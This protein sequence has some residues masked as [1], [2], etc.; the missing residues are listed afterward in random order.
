MQVPAPTP[1]I[2]SFHKV[3]NACEPTALRLCGR[4]GYQIGWGRFNINRLI[5][6]SF[7]LH[8]G[9]EAL[10]H[11]A[12]PSANYLRRDAVEMSLC[13]KC[14]EHYNAIVSVYQK[15]KSIAATKKHTMPLILLTNISTNDHAQREVAALV[16]RLKTFAEVTSATRGR[17]STSKGR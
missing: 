7:R 2:Q 1:R 3:S 17:S 8:R 16:F 15:D 4:L 11:H 5:L 13:F 6:T 9:T 12:F 14:Q 10:L